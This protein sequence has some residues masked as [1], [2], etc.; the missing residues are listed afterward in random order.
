MTLYT[1]GDI[2]RYYAETLVLLFFPGSKFPTDGSGGEPYIH[3]SVLEDDGRVGGRVSIKAEGREVTKEYYPK[4]G[5]C[6]RVGI[7]MCKKLGAGGAMLLCGKEFCNTTPPWGMITGVRP[8]KLVL[9]MYGKGLDESS[10]FDRLVE[11]FLCTPEKASLAVMTANTEN[12]FINAKRRRE[13]SVY[14]AIPFCPTR[15]A[16]CSFVSYSSPK[17][18]GLIPEY[19]KRLSID[20]KNTFSIIK[21]LNLRVATV[22]IGGGTPTT[23]DEIQLE[24][25]MTSIC[26]NI[27]P[28]Q[29]DEFTVE[30]G[31]PDTINLEKMK[32]LKKYGVTRVSVNAQTMNDDILRSIGRK[33]TSREF[34]SAYNDA[35]ESGIRDIN[36]DLIAGLP[37]ESYV[38]FSDSVQR[39]VG[40]APTN[41]T[42][43]TFYV[44]RAADLKN[45]SDIY[46]IEDDNTVKAVDAAQRA[47]LD[48]GYK[49]Y[50]MYKQKNTAA[51]LENA[52]YSFEGHECLYN[53][54]MMEEVHTVF[55]AGAS[56]MT[57][58]VSPDTRNMKIKRLCE[59]KYPYEYLD[60]EKGSALKRYEELRAATLEF[61]DK[62]F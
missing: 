44:K 39:I 28:S 11:D 53:I 40:L 45:N 37:R 16:Y 3:M 15:C 58:L 2:S 17:L 27:E 7:D 13:C 48:A 32:I 29:L 8:A 49:P 38:S 50:Y 1:E 59:T 6:E 60:S 42:V 22:Y 61:Y 36:V 4:C 12:R 24:Y 31:R 46:R 9:D 10:A 33:H 43:H 54:F 56:A 18:L 20:I 41:V 55:G 5:T 52:G 26:V 21:E 35:V 57:K 19:L 51:N 25:L 62:Y 30:A 23:L 14:I 47:I 34:I